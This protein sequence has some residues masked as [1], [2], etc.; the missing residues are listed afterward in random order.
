MLGTGTT[1]PHRE[2]PA[3]PHEGPTARQ[4]A[5]VKPP[6]PQAVSSRDG[7]C[8]GRGACGW[9]TAW[10]E[11]VRGTGRSVFIGLKT[12]LLRLAKRY[13]SF[14]KSEL[15][16]LAQARFSA[17]SVLVLLEVVSLDVGGK[18][19]ASSSPFCRPPAAWLFPPAAAPRS[20]PRDLHCNGGTVWAE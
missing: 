12:R 7:P 5:A 18:G 3:E 14:Q 8:R 17:V 10:A 9:P 13:L 4:C 6:R 19:Q 16:K 1:R 20:V 2:G 15:D 11:A